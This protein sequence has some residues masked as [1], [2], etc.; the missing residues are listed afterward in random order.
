MIAPTQFPG[1]LTLLN[2]LK[3]WHA[4]IFIWISEGTV[5]ALSWDQ[6]LNLSHLLINK[7][8]MK[9]FQKNFPK[10]LI[11]FLKLCQHLMYSHQSLSLICFLV[12]Y[13]ELNTIKT[14]SRYERR[15]CR[16]LDLIIIN[17]RC[18]EASDKNIYLW[19]LHHMTMKF[20]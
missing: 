17:Q 7:R 14:E 4:R 12:V 18:E 6:T 1:V 11:F 2:S 3:I 19:Y 8:L 10:K 16:I 9:P 13:V 15:R 20:D 5:M